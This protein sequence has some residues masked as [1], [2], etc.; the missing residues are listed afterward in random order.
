MKRKCVV[1]L[2]I[3]VLMQVLCGVQ[4]APKAQTAGEKKPTILVENKNFFKNNPIT[5]IYEYL[6]GECPVE[7]VALPSN[8]A[9]REAKIEEIRAEIEAGGGPDAFIL[10][11]HAPNS[12]CT[13]A[14]FPDVE[15]SMAD[16][17]FLPLDTYIKSSFYLDP[18]AQV[19]PVFNAGKVNGEQVVLPLLYR[20][21]TYLLDKAQ[22]QDPNAQYTSFDALKTCKDDTVL[23]VLQAHQASWY[24]AQLA[25][26]ETASEFSVPTAENEVA[27]AEISLT[28]DAWYEDGFAYYAQNKN[29]TYA[30][31][32]P[33]DAGGVTAFVT[34]YAAVNPNTKCAEEVFEYLELFYSDAVQS[35]N[36]LRDKETEITYGALARSNMFALL[37]ADVS[38]VTGEYA[39]ENAELRNEINS[40]INAVRFYG[41]KDRKLLKHAPLG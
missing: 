2:A 3:L 9:E 21:N 26:I 6:Y 33:N 24:G 8:G 17:A 31:T 12:T 14:L 28:G 38:T 19:Q 20:V 35:D 23:S 18:S 4:S 37:S 32:V 13:S 36:G 16:G 15:Q 7:F 1:V 41:E 5:E 39:Y 27:D 34:A 29:D 22:M 10:A 40:R 11:A 25:D 30:L